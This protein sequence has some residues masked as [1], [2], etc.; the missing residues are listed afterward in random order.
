MP[1]DVYCGDTSA[2]IDLPRN[3]PSAVFGVVWDK[4]VGLI[5]EGRLIAPREVLRELLKKEDEVSAWAK[6]NGAM[7]VDLEPAQQVMLTEIM[8]AFPNWVDHLTDR[9]VA[10]PVVIALARSRLAANPGIPCWVVAHEQPGGPGAM[11]IPNVCQQYNVR[12]IRLVDIFV[13]EGW[14]FAL[15]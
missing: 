14:T 10:D 2:L 11:K 3:Y 5:A 7:F 1:N 13:K 6:A 8:T 15:A 12:H 4:L 9:P